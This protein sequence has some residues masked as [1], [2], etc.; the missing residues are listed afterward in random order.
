M[1]WMR[2]D[3]ERD[4]PYYFS[5]DFLKSS[6]SGALVS[7]MVRIDGDQIFRV[8]LGGATDDP[9]V[10]SVFI[11]G[12]RPLRQ[13]PQCVRPVLHGVYFAV[14]YPVYDFGSVAVRREQDD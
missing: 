11:N 2:F 6:F 13:G 1:F 8:N 9:C 4:D 14:C 10:D 7:I 12:P 5:M 3:V